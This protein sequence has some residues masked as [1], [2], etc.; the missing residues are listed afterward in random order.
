ML[1]GLHRT[2]TEAKN[3][4]ENQ[5]FSQKRWPSVVTHTSSVSSGDNDI[6]VTELNLAEEV[7]KL[8]EDKCTSS[9]E[10]LTAYANVKR[11]ALGKKKRRIVEQKTAKAFVLEGIIQQQ[12]R[13]IEKHVQERGGDENKKKHRTV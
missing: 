12:K 7:L 11:R 9:N 3:E 2:I 10:F 8:M 13:P 4:I 5:A 6:P 1:E